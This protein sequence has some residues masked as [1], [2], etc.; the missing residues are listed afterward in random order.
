[1]SAATHV[2]ARMRHPRENGAVPLCTLAHTSSHVA[3]A[4]VDLDEGQLRFLACAHQLAQVFCARSSG[5]GRVAASAAPTPGGSIDGHP[6]VA[7][8]AVKAPTKTRDQKSI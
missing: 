3:P 4:A 5:S 8:A 6:A 7:Q 2:L 1:M